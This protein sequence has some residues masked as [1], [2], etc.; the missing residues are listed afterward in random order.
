MLCSVHLIVSTSHSLAALYQSFVTKTGPLLLL[1]TRLANTEF[2]GWKTKTLR[3][4]RKS[5]RLC[6]ADGKRRSGDYTSSN[7]KDWIRSNQTAVQQHC[8]KVTIWFGL[9]KYSG[10]GNTVISVSLTMLLMHSQLQTCRLKIH[11]HIYET[12]GSTLNTNR[13]LLALL[14]PTITLSSSMTCLTWFAASI[15]IMATRG[16]CQTI[17]INMGCNKLLSQSVFRWAG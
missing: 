2:S 7:P 8:F 16:C 15:N 12:S 11:N 4:K 14:A 13:G 9:E 5:E 1:K 6:W 10:L 3:Y 17:T